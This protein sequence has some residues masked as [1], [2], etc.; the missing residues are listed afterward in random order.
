MKMYMTQLPTTSCSVCLYK[1]FNSLPG[2]TC[3]YI[4]IDAHTR[5]W[6][7]GCLSHIEPFQQDKLVAKLKAFHSYA[8]SQEEFLQ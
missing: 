2:Y 7:Q 3:T 1:A 5:A 8:E 6:T 4:D